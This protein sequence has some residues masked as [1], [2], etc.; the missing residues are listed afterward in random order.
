[1]KPASAKS[2][3]GPEVDRQEADAVGR[4]AADAAVEGPGRAIHAQRQRIHHRVG[5]QRA[6]VV[7]AMVGIPGDAEQHPEV[8]EG[9]EDDDPALQHQSCFRS[10]TSASSAIRNQPGSHQPGIQGRHAE[11]AATLV[12]DRQQ[13]VIEEEAAEQEQEGQALG[14]EA[15]ADHAVISPFVLVPCRDGFA[16]GSSRKK[17]PSG[18][19]RQ[20]KRPSEDR[21]FPLAVNPDQAFCLS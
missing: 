20:K 1:M 10:T 19:R 13:R 18:W 4:G 8:E 12:E 11:Q 7:G 17:M 16:L 21:R 3:V 14:N 15:G 2:R 6:A 9:G 5:D